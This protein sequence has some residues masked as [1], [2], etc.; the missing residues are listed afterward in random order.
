MMDVRREPPQFW[1]HATAVAGVAAALGGILCIPEATRPVGT[2]VVGLG[3][4]ALLATWIVANRKLKEKLAWYEEQLAN[5]DQLEDNVRRQRSA[6]DELADGLDVMIFLTDTRTRILYAN[7]RA[8][9]NFRFD[10]PEGQSILA[11]TLSS[12]IVDLVQEVADGGIPLSVETTLHHPEERNVVVQAWRETSADRVFVSIYDLTSLRRLERIR[13]DFV[14]NVSH[15]L[16]TPLASVRLLAET[17]LDDYDDRE[18]AERYLGKIVK[19]VDRLTRITDDLLT[20]SQLDSGRINKAPTDVTVL[21]SSVVHQLIPKAKAKGLE[22]SLQSAG[23]LKASVDEGQLTQLALNLVDNAINYTS[24][25]SVT[26]KLTE[27]PDTFRMDFIDT[28]LGLAKEHQARIFE[29]F[30]RV[31]KGR[32]RGSGGT[33]LGLAIVKNIAE[34]HGGKVSVTSELGHGSTFIVD[35][36]KE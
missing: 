28:G 8:I 21:V 3:G 29:R 1:P 13:R 11:V 17:L 35:M 30:Y 6:L 34:A 12:E 9:R 24:Q 2:F 26:V 4:I 16:R 19:E 33:G 27:Y 23:P 18:L 5:V 32:S 31:D 15:E 10:D 20:L 25:G 7:E 22:L 14:A 36:P